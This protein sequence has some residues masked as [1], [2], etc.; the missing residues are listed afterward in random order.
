VALDT[1]IWM[2]ERD[3]APATRPSSL[4]LSPP[5]N[6]A[7]KK[8]AENELKGDTLVTLSI[9]EENQNE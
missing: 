8:A 6:A 2:A 5:A 4:R 3:V 1:T 7:L 9:K